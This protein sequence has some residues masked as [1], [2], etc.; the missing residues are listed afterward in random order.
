[1]AAE[2]RFL[3]NSLL[4]GF[5]EFK[6]FYFLLEAT[7]AFKL[8]I[9]TLTLEMVC[10]W[11]R[12]MT[13]NKS[14]GI[15]FNDVCA[16]I[17]S[18]PSK[19]F[20]NVGNDCSYWRKPYS[21]MLLTKATNFC[22]QQKLGMQK[23]TL[24]LE[25]GDLLIFKG[26]LVHSGGASDVQNFRFFSYCPTKSTPPEW[27]NKHKEGK[28]I[29]PIQ[30]KLSE[31]KIT[32]LNLRI[33]TN[34]KSSNFSPEAFQKYLFCSRTNTFFDF[35]MSE[36]FNGIHTHD[37]GDSVVYDGIFE[38][39]KTDTL[40]KTPAKHCL[41]FPSNV[42]LME[43][44]PNL[45]PSIVTTWRYRCACNK[46]RS[47]IFSAKKRVREIAQTKKAE[48]GVHLPLDQSTLG[49]STTLHAQLICISR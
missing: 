4:L 31:S 10:L 35:K 13:F 6:I 43:D 25:C 19:S 16:P 41:H 47:E 26:D 30:Q 15:S 8:S 24:R 39:L 34:P 28:T 49:C 17:Y 40:Y 5:I 32:K 7:R 1:M 42:Q 44:F 2:S 48:G 9:C 36:Y 27:W 14:S 33:I 20:H 21:I 11:V 12:R 45:E 38:Q 22:V 46:E 18:T 37:A 29:F 23:I 3:G